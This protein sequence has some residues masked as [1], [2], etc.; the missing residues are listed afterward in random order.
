MSEVAGFGGT[1]FMGVRRK[2]REAALQALF[3]C[4]LLEEWK[5]EQVFFCFDH[6]EVPAKVRLFA[7]EL[8]TGTIEHRKEIEKRLALASNR[9]SL[10]R[11]NRVDRAIL[12]IASFEILYRR[13]VPVS[14]AINEAI[15]IAKSFGTFESWA[16]VNGVLDRVAEYAAKRPVNGE[17]KAA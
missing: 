14:V 8:I 5:L 4:D 16:F 10:S 2:S 6:F 15:E 7:D 11:M 13:D 9:W 3:M 17:P 1:D 12:Y